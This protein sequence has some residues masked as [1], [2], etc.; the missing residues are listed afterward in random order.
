MTHEQALQTG[1]QLI[2]EGLITDQEQIFESFKT[3]PSKKSK[4]TSK[5]SDEL[6]SKASA[7]K[8]QHQKVSVRKTELPKKDNWTPEVQEFFD[9][10]KGPSLGERVHKKV[11]VL[12]PEDFGIKQIF[13]RP[14][15]KPFRKNWVDVEIK[16]IAAMLYHSDSLGDARKLLDIDEA[17]CK[18]YQIRKKQSNLD[19][20]TADFT[21]E[22]NSLMEEFTLIGRQVNVVL[23][24]MRGRLDG[25]D[26]FNKQLIGVIDIA[27][28]E[29]DSAVTEKKERLEKERIEKE[30]KERIAREEK[31]RQLVELAL[32][33]QAE[34]ET[35]EFLAAEKRLKEEAEE[36]KVS[37]EDSEKA[38]GSEKKQ[39]NV[40]KGVLPKLK[41]QNT[42]RKKGRANV[43][44]L[45]SQKP[46]IKP[47]K[48]QKASA[49]AAKVSDKPEAEEN[50]QKVE[51]KKQEEAEKQSVEGEIKIDTGSKDVEVEESK[52]QEEEKEIVYADLN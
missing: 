16:L 8:S 26:N 20:E 2:N 37:V 36:K 27:Q 4:V 17:T 12:V 10:S 41:P 9:E 51:E 33:A 39:P 14:K 46:V 7:R 19:V 43:S 23:H 50:S 45:V 42:M 28:E 21:A 5:K 13:D 6:S 31:E 49:A 1:L 32:M 47:Q 48:K 15:N 38:P 29:I 35:R 34:A 3:L 25:Q 22:Q 40:K 30:E 44:K 52:K 11:R 18:D 24:H